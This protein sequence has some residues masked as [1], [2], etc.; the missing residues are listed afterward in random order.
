MFACL[1]RRPGLLQGPGRQPGRVSCALD[2]LV[3]HCGVR[4]P[5]PVWTRFPQR[6]PPLSEG[7]GRG[8]AVNGGL[9]APGSTQTGS[10]ARA[11]ESGSPF[12]SERRW[13]VHAKT[14]SPGTFL[15]RGRSNAPRLI[16]D[17]VGPV[18]G[19]L[20]CPPPLGVGEGYRRRY[21]GVSGRDPGLATCMGTRT[22]GTLALHMHARTHH[23]HSH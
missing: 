8:L 6:A 14:A 5:L 15:P 10:G 4:T 3:A 17:R 12:G 20:L 9:R 11:W 19:Y 2:L 1:A 21:S 7:L 18:V 13:A 23:A 22:V 16:P